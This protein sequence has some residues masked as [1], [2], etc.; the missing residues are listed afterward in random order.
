MAA[1]LS[2]RLTTTASEATV[3]AVGQRLNFSGDELQQQTS[4]S[5]PLINLDDFQLDPRFTGVDGTGYAAV[6]LDTGIDL[7][8][9]FFGPDLTLDGVADRIVYNQDFTGS[10][11]DAQDVNGHGSNVSSIVASQDAVYPGVAP[12]A[13]IIHLQ[14]L[15]DAGFGSFG[16]VEAALQ[17]VV[18]NA[19]TYNIVTVNMSLADS[20]N[21]QV[22]VGDYGLDDEL[23]A[24]AALDVVVVSA[25]GN[26]FYNNGSTPGVAYPAAD[27]N[28]L[29]VSAVWDGDNGGP[30]QWGTG[31]IDYTTDADRL[32]SFSQRHPTLTDILAPG[33]IISGADAVGGISTYAGT[34]QASPHIAGVAVLAQQIADDALGRRLTNQEFLDLLQDTAVVVNDG[35]DEDDNVINTDANYARIDMFALADAID[36]LGKIH[37]VSSSPADDGLVTTQIT[38]FAIDFSTPYLAASIDAGDLTVNGIPADSV[39]LTDDDTLTFGFVVSPITTQGLQSMQIGAGAIEDESFE[40]IDQFDS[41]F[42]WDA[43]PMQVVTSVPTANSVAAL[44]LTTI[45]IDLNEAYDP[46]SLGLDDL[47]VTIGSVAGVTPIDT[48][49]VEY[50]ITGINGEGTLTARI[51]EGALSDSYGN[52]IAEF[53]SVYTLDFVSIPLGD[54]TQGIDTLGSLQLEQTIPGSIQDSSDLDTFVVSLEAN[55]SISVVVKGDASLQPKV[56]ILNPS[57]ILQASASSFTPGDPVYVQSVAVNSTGNYSVEVSSTG[58]TTGDYEVTIIVNGDV[59]L[60]ELGA[61]DNDTLG[62]AQN[63]DSSL[64]EIEPTASRTL[65]SGA[66][67]GGVLKVGPDQFGYE[68]LVIP[69]EFDDIST[70]G[71]AIF[72]DNQFGVDNASSILNAI[73]LNGFS[74]SFYGVVYTSAFIS[75]NG[76]ISFFAPETS[77]NNSDL[78]QSPILPTIAA[79]WDDLFIDTTPESAVYWEV[80]GSGSNQQLVV[81]W[82]EVQFLGAGTGDVITF[83]AILDESDGTIQL[84]YLDLDSSHPDSGGASATVG[85]KDLN[86]QIPGQSDN[87]LLVAQDEGPSAFLDSGVSVKIG[88]GI[89]PNPHPDYYAISLSDGDRISV[90]ATSEW[91]GTLTLDLRDDTDTVLYSATTADNV[92]VAIDGYEVTADGIYYIRIDGVSA[93]DYQLLVTR[94]ATF[95]TEVNN[96]LTAAQPLPKSGVAFGSV[97]FGTSSSSSSGTPV[98]GPLDIIANPISLGFASDGSFVGSTLGARHNGV[99][100]LDFGTALAAY[101]VAFDGATHTNGSPATGSDFPVSMEDISSGSQH[102]VRI[103]GTISPGVEFERVVLWNDGD[104]YA[105]ITTSITNNTAGTLDNVALLENQDPDPGGDV[106]TANDVLANGNLVV[107][108]SLFNG[109]LGLGTLD[110]RGVV[111]AEGNLVTDPF[112][113][114]DS[115]QDPYGKTADLSINLAFDLGSLQPGERSEASFVMVMGPSIDAVEETFS[116]ASLD[117]LYKSDDYYSIDLAP[118]ETVVI[119]TRTPGESTGQ[120]VNTLDPAVELYDP[121]GAPVAFDSNSALDGKNALLS[122]TTTVAGTYQVRVLAESDSQGE[123]V[124]VVNQAPTAAISGPPTAVPYQP[125][126]FTLTATDP[127]PSDQAGDFTFHID[128]DNDGTVDR[129]I[130]GPSGLQVTTSFATFGDQTIQVTAMDAREATGEETLESISVS[131]VELQPDE[132][133]PALMNFAFGGTTGIDQIQL[134]ETGVESLN[135]ITLVLNGSLVSTA[136]NFTGITGRI[137]VYTGSGDDIVAATSLTDLALEVY[138]GSGQDVLLGGLANDVLVGGDGN[139]TLVG[140]DGNDTLWADSVDGAEGAKGGDLAIGGFG[141][142]LIVGDGSEGGD[143]FLYGN[144]GNDTV[145]AG[146]GLDFVDGGDDDD[147]IYGGDGAEGSNDQLFGGDGNDFIDGGVGVDTISGGSG[148]DFIVGGVAGETQVSGDLISGDSGEDI[149]LAGTLLFDLEDLDDAVDAIMAEWTSTRDYATR[150]ENINGTGTGPRANGDTFLQVGL[151]IEGNPLVDELSGGSDLDW[152]LYTLSQ[153]ILSDLEGGETET[154]LPP[155]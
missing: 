18:A 84:N 5:G 74:F 25:A 148:R 2:S 1:E 138:G 90:A 36:A 107:G 71:T 9:P 129:I 85:I 65:I 31:A 95:D 88:V 105:M 76:L 106:I 89:V 79:F 122:Y 75:S 46:G 113:V 41:V 137:L 80:K 47:A 153:D 149:L 87:R 73:D 34:S 52:P 126:T 112:E 10:D 140:G 66:V 40:P 14:V 57:A 19:A 103:F 145:L 141:D 147:R 49:T 120:G 32:A 144:E 8:H 152:F 96:E 37:V 86:F 22:A 15:D 12:G 38:E 62:T 83:Q 43:V 127:N 154:D 92:D 134:I 68:A 24:L 104:D 155:I 53:T 98:S 6:I 100:Y 28:S 111:S 115:P 4:L 108:G 150:I 3:S 151:T 81:Q 29:A 23:A 109:V 77:P 93:T 54:L 59:E 117:T 26:S 27:P 51:S 99:E 13:D 143:D 44:P 135:F 123:Y 102:G 121:F 48:D 118:N 91:R 11:P 116:Q 82:N 21:R 146:G 30:F 139:D 132:D 39:A 94:N 69:Y 61:I 70:T 33:A 136:E 60:E 58:G 35:D 55:Q 130:T 101:T 16:D 56:R 131:Q 45:R 119:T 142:D 114:L 124:L 78:T 133:E 110:P 67:E 63:L 72:D 50:T 125:R 17:W 7:D 128:W 42:R 20:S 64:V 97:G